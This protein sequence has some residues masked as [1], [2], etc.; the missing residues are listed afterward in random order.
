[1][2][3]LRKVFGALPKDQKESLVKLMNE[4]TAKFAALPENEQAEHRRAQR[5]S[6]VRGEL[7]LAHEE[8]SF[9]KATDIVKKVI[10]EAAS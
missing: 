1:M 6:W 9:E 7:M 10:K 3:D 4:A 2:S 5:L 8:M